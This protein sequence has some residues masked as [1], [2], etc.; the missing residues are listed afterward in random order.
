MGEARVWLSEGRRYEWHPRAPGG[1]FNCLEC[2]AKT[3]AGVWA[4]LQS[5]WGL[6]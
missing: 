6:W 3:K 4:A 2:S 5:S 1:A